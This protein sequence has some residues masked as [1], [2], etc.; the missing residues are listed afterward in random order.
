ME[1]R[2]QVCLT[3]VDRE[4]DDY[5]C[6]CCCNH[7]LSEE[8]EKRTDVRGS[9]MHGFYSNM[10]T[11]NISMGGDVATNATSAY[12]TGSDRQH[13]LLQTDGDKPP[14]ASSKATSLLPASDSG[15][16]NP[17]SRKEVQSEVTNEHSSSTTSRKRPADDDG[18]EIMSHSDLPKHSATQGEESSSV[19]LPHSESSAC[20]IIGKEEKLLSARERYL[21]RKKSAV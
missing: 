14:V 10:L 16:S 3:I 12:T 11:K 21:A 19:S 15:L 7:R 9:G 20:I 17:S 1:L 2:R 5:N 8:I 6:D 18:E 13:S 4:R